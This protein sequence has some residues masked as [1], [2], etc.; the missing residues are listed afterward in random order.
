MT[1]TASRILGELSR[2]GILLVQ[3]K[4]L[5]CVVASV[6]AEPVAGSWWSHPRAR[7]IYAVLSELSDHPD[8]LVAVL[9]RGKNTLVHRALWPALVRIAES[10]E[11]WQ[12]HGLSPAARGLLGQIRRAA[13]PIQAKRPA[14]KALAGR[15]LVCCRETHTASGRHEL[16]VQSWSRWAAGAGIVPVASIEEARAVFESACTAIG[17]PVTVL[18]W[19]VKVRSSPAVANRPARSRRP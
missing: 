17:A 11:P 6:V 13:D 3:D 10:A 19:S 16:A 12:I 7:E 2:H 18:P 8:V 9:L 14:V 1:P 4:H 5:P 15:L